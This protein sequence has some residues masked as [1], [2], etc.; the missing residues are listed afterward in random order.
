MRSPR[1]SAGGLRGRLECQ[2]HAAKGLNE[3][4]K[5]FFNLRVGYSQRQSGLGSPVP[6]NS[7]PA[8]VHPNDAVPMGAV[9]SWDEHFRFDVSALTE[10]VLYISLWD[11][12]TGKQTT[13]MELDFQKMASRDPPKAD[14][15]IPLVAL[16]REQASP[17]SSGAAPGPAPVCG[18]VRMSFEFHHSAEGTPRLPSPRD[19]FPLM[20]V[21]SEA[22]F[23]LVTAPC[24]E[25]E[26]AHAPDDLEAARAAAGSPPAEPGT[27]ERIQSAAT[28]PPPKQRP[29]PS[30]CSP[31][32]DLDGCERA[33]SSSA[34]ALTPRKH[35]ALLESRLRGRAGASST[36]PPAGG[37][38]PAWCERHGCTS[39]PRVDVRPPAYRQALPR[40]CA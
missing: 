22:P 12:A 17:G 2:L 35:R 10:P 37:C 24:G 26:Q 14:L 8:T 40:P 25:P 5:P 18:T 27:P 38:A 1:A 16:T 28:S 15:W 32:G 31:S 6:A 29:S 13:R 11:A 3:L 7:S 33:F 39:P 34:S 23:T 9:F 36:P 20:P 21:A 4:S 30:R 19:L